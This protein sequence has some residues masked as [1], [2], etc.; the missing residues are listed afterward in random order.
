MIVKPRPRLRGLRRGPY[1]KKREAAL[2]WS[3][4]SG[5]WRGEAAETAAPL[6]LGSSPLSSLV[7]GRTSCFL[8]TASADPD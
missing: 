4:D 3:E 1:R 5:D 7:P 8:V 2:A 6:V